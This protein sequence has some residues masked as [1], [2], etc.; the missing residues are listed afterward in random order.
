MKRKKPT[1]FKT[2]L[3]VQ[4]K[5]LREVLKMAA[6]VKDLQDAIQG[7]SDAVDADVAQDLKVVE[8]INALLAAIAAGG[9]TADFQPQIDQLKAVSSKLSS[10]N[11]AVQAAIDAAVP[12]TP[13]A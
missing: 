5:I 10:D 12:P 1:Q 11:A 8:A 4:K 3:A 6:T 9:S 13:A 2:E 7:I